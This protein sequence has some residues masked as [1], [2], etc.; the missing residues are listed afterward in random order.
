MEDTGVEV[1]AQWWR[2]VYL[3]K[4]ASDGPFE[5][6]TDAESKIT[7]YNKIKNFFKVALVI[8]IICFFIEL[9]ATINNDS[10]IFGIFTV[11]AAAIS[12]A[13]L[14]IV[15]KCKWKIQQYKHEINMK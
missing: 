5:M 1:I 4:K 15:W 12:L 13:M 2:W 6:Y 3:Q 9:K 14:Q 11:L 10:Y 7:Q 8:E